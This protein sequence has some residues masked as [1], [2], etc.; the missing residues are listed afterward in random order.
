[1]DKE[2][3]KVNE[4]ADKVSQVMA[5]MIFDSNN[6]RLD[7]DKLNIYAYTLDYYGRNLK[8]IGTCIENLQK[9]IDD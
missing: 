1:M 2:L 4:I 3:E 6:G 8:R 5:D 7:K 9:T